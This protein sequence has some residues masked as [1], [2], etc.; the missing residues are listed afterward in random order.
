[1]KLRILFSA[2]LITQ[3][4]WSLNTMKEE[5]S[6]VASL[7]KR[8]EIVSESSDGL[9]DGSGAVP[10]L[11]ALASLPKRIALVSFYITPQNTKSNL[12]KSNRST[13]I[14]TTLHKVSLPTIKKVFKDNGM[15]V[16]EPSEFLTDDVKKKA[17]SEIKFNYTGDAEQ[18]AEGA[19]KPRSQNE[20]DATAGVVPGYATIDDIH[21]T[22]QF[23]PIT[24]VLGST[25]PKAL[26]VDAVLVVNVYVGA[27]KHGSALMN[28]SMYLFGPNPVAAPLEGAPKIPFTLEY[29]PGLAY[30]VAT[31][32][33]NFEKVRLIPE[34]REDDTVEDVK[35]YVGF[36]KITE[37][38][39]NRIGSHLKAKTAKK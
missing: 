24:N 9:P 31:Y 32:K 2:L 6:D 28:T 14:A 35:D 18:F 30:A 29:R 7:E 12:F 36:E 1:M 13:L 11:K 10:R 22:L 23:S 37:A 20:D 25:L 19:K 5:A 8:I 26:G 17:F 4:A 21:F 3:L 16:L 39:A 38:L 34:D 33:K 15:E 27:N